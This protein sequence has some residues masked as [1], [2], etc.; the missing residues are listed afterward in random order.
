MTKQIL[1]QISKSEYIEI[2]S[3]LKEAKLTIAQHYMFLE[4][5][6]IEA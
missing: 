3:A 2:K 6:S 5:V 4:N 1:S